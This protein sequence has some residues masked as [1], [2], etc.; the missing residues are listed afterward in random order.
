MPFA[1][2]LLE[3]NTNRVRVCVC[4][5]I[6]T[7]ISDLTHASNGRVAA[8]V[9]VIVDEQRQQHDA[10]EQQRRME[11]RVDLAQQ[12]EN[13]RHH[14]DLQHVL[15]ERILVDVLG[16]RAENDQQRHAERLERN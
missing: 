7:Y 10:I 6:S 14:V 8:L 3:V 16:R 4:M 1:V 9:F 11:R 2:T 12:L 5:S 15:H 13:A